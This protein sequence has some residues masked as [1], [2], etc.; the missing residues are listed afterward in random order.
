MI[1]ACLSVALVKVIEELT[2]LDSGLVAQARLQ[3]R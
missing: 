2:G 1:A 3:A